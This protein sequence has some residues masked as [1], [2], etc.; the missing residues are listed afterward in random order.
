M[1]ALTTNM[2]ILGLAITPQ[3]AAE[4]FHEFASG[5]R[6]GLPPPPPVCQTVETLTL[7][8]RAPVAAYCEAGVPLGGLSRSRA[9]DWAYRVLTE[10]TVGNG[11]VSNLPDEPHAWLWC[12]DVASADMTALGALVRAVS[13]KTPTIAVI[14]CAEFDPNAQP[15]MVVDPYGKPAIAG[16]KCSVTLTDP[17]GEGLYGVGTGGFELAAVNYPAL[18]ALRLAMRDHQ[19]SFVDVDGVTRLAAFAEDWEVPE[20]SLVSAR[21]WLTGEQAFWT[22][23]PAG[24]RTVAVGTG[25]STYAKRVLELDRWALG[26]LT[27]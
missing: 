10:N 17:L 2:H 23:V 1:I 15:S 22:R 5:K 25:S 21:R 26:A 8:T 6:E 7:I 16:S 9:M 18:Q 12:D 20:D 24:V 27:P 13:S 19:L 11:S 14:P 3:G 4:L